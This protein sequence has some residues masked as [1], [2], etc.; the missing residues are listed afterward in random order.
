MV[1]LR[2]ELGFHC[3]LLGVVYVLLLFSLP[4]MLVVHYLDGHLCAHRWK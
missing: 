2:F 1:P 4:A 3:G